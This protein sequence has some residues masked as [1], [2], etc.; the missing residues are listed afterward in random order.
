MLKFLR[1]GFFA[2]SFCA[3]SSCAF[4]EEIVCDRP[5]SEKI[6]YTL[7]H[8]SRA[9]RDT[10][11]ELAVYNLEDQLERIFEVAP[12]TM[13]RA[14]CDLDT[15]FVSKEFRE[16]SAGY[17]KHTEM[18]LS[19]Y[20]IH[21]FQRTME[22]LIEREFA[23]YGTGATFISRD[24]GYAPQDLR[25]TDAHSLQ[26]E[27]E[28]TKGRIA[29]LNYAFA[30][31]MFHEFAHFMENHPTYNNHH[32]FGYFSCNG[33]YQ[34]KNNYRVHALDQ[35]LK[36][37]AITLRQHPKIGQDSS[38]LREMERGNYST[39]YA[40][41]NYK[42]DFAELLAEYIMYEH[43]GVNFRIWKGEE[44]LFERAKQFANDAMQPKL[45]VVKLALEFPD[46]A[47]KEKRAIR[48][49]RKLCRGLFDPTLMTRLP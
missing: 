44:V 41:A 26:Y 21:L 4:A 2:A 37:Y 27:V 6:C 29:G 46:L 45:A 3:F 19:W 25:L 34:S 33:Q 18:W 39:F 15:L 7:D 24:F 30:Y 40:S 43:L 23:H 5:I 8:E 48:T 1:R 20:A 10:P 42:E 13:Q 35:K 38:I 28:Y 17:Q 11:E 9:C 36:G 16:H 14:F 12:K 22:N 47:K 31:L 49:D 32:R